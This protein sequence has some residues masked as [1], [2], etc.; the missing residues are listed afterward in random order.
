MTLGGGTAQAATC[1]VPTLAHPTIQSAVNDPTCDPIEVTAG[2]YVENV[3]IGRSLTLNGAQAG[4]SAPGRVGPESIVQGANPL[5]SNPVIAI[6]FANVV[7]DGFTLKNSVTTGAAIGIAVRGAGH[8]ALITNNIIDTVSSADLNGTAQAIYLQSGPDN[9][10]IEANEMKNVQ[11]ARSAKGVLVGDNGAANAA[12]STLIQGN[13]ILNITSND[14]GSYGISVANAIPPV[15]DLEIR[16]N[17]ITTLT[18]TGLTGWIHAIGLEGNTPGVIVEGNS[19]SGFVT[20]SLDAVAVFFEVNPSFSTA[21]VNQNNF[22]VTIAAF[23]IAVH[24]AIVG[25]G[26]VD[27]TCN[28]WGDPNGPG[29]VGPGLGAK[30]SPRVIYTP[31]LTAPTSVGACI[32]GASTPGKVTGGGQI[33]SDPVFSAFGDLLSLPAL[34]PSLAGPTSQATFGFV[35]TCCAPSGNLEYNDHAADTR[36]KAESING[37]FISSAGTSCPAPG[38]RHA[39]FTGTAQVIRSTGTTTEFFTVE[40]DDCGEPGTADS[41]GIKTTTY[42]NGPSPLIGGNIRIH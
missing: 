35:V 11:S 17:T 40:V 23:G 10:T 41:F 9:V 6:N 26:D 33:E 4:I 29:P 20:G 5:G 12:L 1:N 25:T 15:F 27:G 36:I 7:V 8:G 19:I 3:T 22:D 13:S 31:W 30:V 24:P 42:S 28:W 38:G 37:L 14:R 32:G 34:V 18:A 39:T 2:L 21:N 16:D